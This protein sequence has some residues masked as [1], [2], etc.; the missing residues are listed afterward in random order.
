MRKFSSH[1]AP[2]IP[3]ATSAAAAAAGGPPPPVPGGEA[4]TGRVWRGKKPWELSE[5]R[6]FGKVMKDSERS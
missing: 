3:R 1:A 6:K 5:I 4:T 2:A